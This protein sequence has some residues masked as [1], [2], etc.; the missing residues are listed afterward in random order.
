LWRESAKESNEFQF[1]IDRGEEERLLNRIRI[2][3]WWNKRYFKRVEQNDEEW[4]E[5]FWLEVEEKEQNFE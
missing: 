4:E 5:D 2:R 3:D 1:E